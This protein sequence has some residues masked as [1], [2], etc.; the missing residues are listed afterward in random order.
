M[1]NGLETAVRRLC[2]AFPEAEELSSH[3]A[4]NFWLYIAILL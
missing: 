2:F 1:A 4:P 3:G